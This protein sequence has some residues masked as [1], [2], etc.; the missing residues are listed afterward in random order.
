MFL[1][2][3]YRGTKGSRKEVS[4]QNIHWSLLPRSCVHVTL[5]SLASSGCRRA[6]LPLG[7]L[8]WTWLLSRRLQPLFWQRNM[9]SLLTPWNTMTAAS[10][11][12]S[13]EASP[14]VRRH[15][16]FFSRCFV[17]L[18]HL[19]TTEFFQNSFSFPLWTSRTGFENVTRAS[20]RAE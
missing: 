12:H 11:G 14:A 3:R 20:S 15:V 18:Q 1:R 6:N 10:C 7:E 16:V 4:R 5:A 8:T 2:N 9:A 17:M 13:N 19:A